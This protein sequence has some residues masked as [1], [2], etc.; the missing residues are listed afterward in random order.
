MAIINV[1]VKLV[2]D[3]DVQDL[4][5]VVENMDYNFVYLDEK[6]ADNLILDTEITN[7]VYW[8]D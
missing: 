7:V 3:D 1:T 5:D 2:V 4:T 8:E 6:T